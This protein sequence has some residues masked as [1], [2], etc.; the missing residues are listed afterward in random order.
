MTNIEVLKQVK[1]NLVFI[2]TSST[3]EMALET[4]QFFPLSFIE[5]LLAEIEE[6]EERCGEKADDQS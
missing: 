3:L 6:L 1:R 5:K 2:E 4:G